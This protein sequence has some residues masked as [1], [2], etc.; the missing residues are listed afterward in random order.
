MNNYEKFI[1]WIETRYRVYL[2]KEVYGESKPWTRDATFQSTYFCNVHREND[3]VTKWIRTNYA[4]KEVFKDLAGFNMM[5]ARFVNKP[6]SLEAM[7]WPFRAWTVFEKS[8]FR[9]VMSQPGSWGSAYIVSTNGRTMPKHEYISGLLSAA[10]SHFEQAGGALPCLSLRT[11]HTALQG[12]SGIASFMAGQ[13]VADLKNTNGHP[14][15]SAPDWW[16][17]VAPGPGSLRG[18]SWVM[19]QEK[20]YPRWFD[21]QI[22]ILRKRVDTDLSINVPA[23]CNQDLQNCLCEFDKYMRVSTG[24]G[25]SKRKYAGA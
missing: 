9:E 6:S 2:K 23:F 13:I 14:L 19:E 25:R 20:V 18:M 10:Y 4:E 12:L 11:A 24:A 7:G 15:Q 1:W 16:T 5:V 8:S 21:E 17:F 3:R 22:G